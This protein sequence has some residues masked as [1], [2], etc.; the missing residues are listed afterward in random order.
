MGLVV[1]RFK[2]LQYPAS[3]SD[4]MRYRLYAGAPWVILISGVALI[5]IEKWLA[6]VMAIIIAIP[7]RSALARVYNRRIVM[8]KGKDGRSRSGVRGR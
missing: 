2:P 6:G 1:E 5:S 8:S 7:V 3:F 4:E